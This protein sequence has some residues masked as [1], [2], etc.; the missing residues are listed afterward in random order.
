MMKKALIPL[1]LLAIV[2]ALSG[3]QLPGIETQ[4]TS[5]NGI[6]IKEFGFDYS[7]IYSEESTGLSLTLQN[8]GGVKGELKEIAIFGVD[9]GSPE[10]PTA[11]ALTWGYG[12][13]NDLKLEDGDELIDE[14]LLPPDPTSGYE[15]DEY[16]AEWVFDSPTDIKS[17]TTYEF[18]TRVKYDYTTT[19]TGKITIVDNDYLRSLPADE[20]EALI[21]VGGVQDAS[22]TGGPLSLAAASGRHF[23]LR[24]GE[25]GPS[26]TRPIKFRISNVGS[27]FPYIN[28]YSNTNLHYVVITADDGVTCGIGTDDAKIK[29]ARGKTGVISCDFEPPEHG[30]F[31]N[32][33]DKMFS[34][35]LEYG[36]YVDSA[37]SITVNPVLE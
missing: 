16:Y 19:F 33:V 17:T 5:S 23:I 20:R 9:F 24:S 12:T 8:V 34:V 26:D 30:S 13:V 7:P 18:Q 21:K 14:E 29:L 36:Y 28:P 1:S 4:L 32:K 11:G 2:V 35:T 31:T 10:S 15:G 37:T 3:C 25:G 6:I 27:G 22:V